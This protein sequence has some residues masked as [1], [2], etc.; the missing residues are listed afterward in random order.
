[1]QLADDSG[2]LALDGRAAL[3]IERRIVFLG[4]HSGLHLRLLRS[5]VDT[6]DRSLL[7]LEDVADRC[8][9]LLLNRARLVRVVA[10]V[11]DAELGGLHGAQG[12]DTQRLGHIGADVIA[13]PHRRLIVRVVVPDHNL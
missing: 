12:L 2:H 10:G 8:L 9:I 6:K 1:M 4:R 3:R 13:D 11:V 5:V 7:L